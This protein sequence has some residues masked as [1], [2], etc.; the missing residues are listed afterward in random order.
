MFGCRVSIEFH[1]TDYP[2]SM[3]SPTAG[4]CPMFSYLDCCWLCTDDTK[5]LLLM[6]VVISKTSLKNFHQ[7]IFAGTVLALWLAML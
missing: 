3:T 2:T 5:C 4:Y 7:E 6:L 1:Y